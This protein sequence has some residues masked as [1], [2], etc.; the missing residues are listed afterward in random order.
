MS[1]HRP[2]EGLVVVDFTRV[3]SGPYCTMMLADLGAEVIKV[4][5]KGL[6]DD[7]HQYLP[8][9]DPTKESGYFMYYNRNKMSIELD[10]KDPE[11][12]EIVYRICENADIVVENFAPGVADRLHIGYEDIKKR[13]PKIIYGS[14]SGFGQTGPYRS[15]A[16]YDIIAQAMGGYMA[17]TGFKGGIPL[18]LGT[19]IADAGAGIQMAYA[20]LAAVYYREKNG[21][22]QYV[23][24][25]MQDTV[26]S[27]MENFIMMKTYGGITP[28]RNGNSNLG[29][30]PFNTFRT[31]DDRY[32][33]IAVANDAM[34]E[35]CMDA[36]GKSDIVHD[37]RF[38]SNKYRKE[39]EP[40][41]NAIMEEWTETKTVEEVCEVMDA[42]KVPVGPILDIDQL[43][44]DPQLIE[45]EMIVEMNHTTEGKVK[46]PGCPLKFSETK[47][48]VYNSSPLLGEHTCHIL[49]KYGKYSDD[50]IHELYE[51][52]TIFQ[53]K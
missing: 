1:K 15:K 27:T 43:L 49:R 19:S 14:I 34:F 31:K 22:G 36:I 24:V 32:V 16:A 18:K 51:C 9:P 39:N 41:L 25:S 45:R 53:D 42:A 3:Y 17:V 11:A 38:C 13:N 52:G 35:R 2:L 40:I 7:S 37:S 26:F 33:C 48:D 20:L 10:L 47:V 5:R 8:L 44:E 23:D 50:E 28:T 46:M 12:T 6:G 29:A 30:A 21:I 4:E